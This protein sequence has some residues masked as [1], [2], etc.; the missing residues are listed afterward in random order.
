MTLLAARGIELLVAQSYCKNLGLYAQKKALE[1]INVVCTSAN[2]A[3]KCHEQNILFFDHFLVYGQ[4]AFPQN[5][6]MIRWTNAQLA[7]YQGRL[8]HITFP[9]QTHHCTCLLDVYLVQNCIVYFMIF[10]WI[11][12]ICA[13]VGFFE[14]GRH[15][16]LI[17]MFCQQ[18][19]AQKRNHC[20]ISLSLPIGVH[21]WHSNHRVGV[22]FLINNVMIFFNWYDA[23]MFYCIKCGGKLLERK[24]WLLFCMA[25]T[26]F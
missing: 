2:A 26:H 13:E 17:M 18:L 25:N 4:L 1:P 19:S 22:G 8:Y 5:I 21:R 12:H 14:L 23:C 16:K 3:A 9:C 24:R 7:L 10:L 6:C 11:Y 20:E 15:W